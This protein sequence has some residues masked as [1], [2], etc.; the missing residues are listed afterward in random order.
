MKLDIYVHGSDE[1]MVYKVR[2]RGSRVWIKTARP[3]VAE[4]LAEKIEKLLTSGDQLE[5]RRIGFQETKEP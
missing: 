1:I 5:P 4:C 2:T 3:G